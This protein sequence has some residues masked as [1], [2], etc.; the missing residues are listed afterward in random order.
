MAKRIDFRILFDRLSHIS[1]DLGTLKKYIWCF[2]LLIIFLVAK[3][4]SDI[5]ISYVGEKIGT[6]VPGTSI[7][8]KPSVDIEPPPPPEFKTFNIITRRNIF[9]P[10][11]PEEDLIEQLREGKM[12]LD[13]AGAIPSTQP[14]DLIGTI[15]LS[16]TSRSVA[17][18]KNREKN[19]VESYQSGDLLTSALRV[20]KINPHKVY[21]QNLDSGQLEYI[22]LREE[23]STLAMAQTYEPVSGGIREMG[24]GQ[25]IIDRGAL[26][27]TLAN[28][29]EILTHARAVPNIVDGKIQGFKIF[30]IKPGS[31]Y[32]QLGVR[33][34]D[35]VKRINGVDLDSPAKA[36]EFYGI[37]A[38][39][40]EISLDID[41]E[42]QK[43]SYTYTI[44]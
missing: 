17:A 19:E 28:P 14:F 33:N 41:R 35:T 42:G 6:S 2:H 38:S 29:N 27:A 25:F 23:E 4:A 11:A 10:N 21:F 30:S 15:I 16:E 31:V 26:E 40:S 34:G 20:Y 8:A 43:L 18:I 5:L 3:S 7:T 24:G 36:L 39:A 44:R 22:E 32:E 13:E 37:I 9:N 12:G 1:F